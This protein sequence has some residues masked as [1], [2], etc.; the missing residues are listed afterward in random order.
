MFYINDNHG[1][2]QDR[3]T[4]ESMIDEQSWGV[5]YL[6]GTA[7]NSRP[8][9]GGLRGMESWQ[10][11]TFQRQTILASGSMGQPSLKFRI[12]VFRPSTRLSR[13]LNTSPPAI[14]V[15]LSIRADFPS[16]TPACLAMRVSRGG[17]MARITTR[18][19][20]FSSGT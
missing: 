4:G 8:V 16:T 11:W 2:L 18:S 1:I 12:S 17:F 6:I 9:S 7:S 13:T 19:A 5:T 20:G 14:P 10:G 3:V 15:P